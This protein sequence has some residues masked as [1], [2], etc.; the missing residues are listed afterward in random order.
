[1]VQVRL[2]NMGASEEWIDE[3]FQEKARQYAFPIIG[4]QLGLGITLLLV[5][6]FIPEPSGFALMLAPFGAA[7][8][9]FAL[10]TSMRCISAAT[11]GDGQ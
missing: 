9:G 1:M 11:T 10:A 2:E 8:I 5:R 6:R 4:T 7:C 3:F